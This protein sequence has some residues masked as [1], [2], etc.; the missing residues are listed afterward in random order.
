MVDKELIKPSA[1]ANPDTFTYNWDATYLTASHA[2]DKRSSFFLATGFFEQPKVEAMCRDLIK[3][4][5]GENIVDTE[6]GKTYYG[7]RL[8][9][10]NEAMVTKLQARQAVADEINK[11]WQV[12]NLDSTDWQNFATLSKEAEELL[13][14][15]YLNFMFDTNSRTVAQKQLGLTELVNSYN[16]VNMADYPESVDS[17]VKSSAENSFDGTGAAEKTEAQKLAA[18]LLYRLLHADVDATDASGKLIRYQDASA[19]LGK[20]AVDT[21]NVRA[22]ASNAANAAY[23][24][25]M[26]A[27]QRQSVTTGTFVQ[28]NASG[29]TMYIY[30]NQLNPYF[31]IDLQEQLR[32][33]RATDGTVIT[34]DLVTV[35]QAQQLAAAAGK[36]IAQYNCS[37]PEKMSIQGRATAGAK[38]IATSWNPAGDTMQTADLNSTGSTMYTETKA[39]A[40][41]TYAM[42]SSAIVVLKPQ[43]SSTGAAQQYVAYSITAN[44]DAVAKKTSRTPNN[45]NGTDVEYS[46]DKNFELSGTAAASEAAK[47]KI[48]VMVYYQNSELHTSG[49]AVIDEGFATSTTDSTTNTGWSEKIAVKDR[50]DSTIYQYF[51][52]SVRS[53]RQQ[54]GS[55]GNDWLQYEMLYREFFN[56]GMRQW[57]FVSANEP[58]TP[59]AD[60]PDFGTSDLGSFIY[61]INPANVSDKNSLDYQVVSEY[62]TALAGNMNNAARAAT[63][64]KDKMVTLL[65]SSADYR[66]AVRSAL[67]DS[68]NTY[69]R[70]YGSTANWSQQLRYPNGTLV[71]VHVLDRW[72]NHVNRVFLIEKLD[73]TAPEVTAEEIGTVTINEP[74]GSGVKA[75]DAFVYAGTQGSSLYVDYHFD[76]YRAKNTTTTYYDENHFTIGGLTPNKLYTIGAMNNAEL[77]GSAN[78]KADAEGKITITVETGEYS[79]MTYNVANA[80]QV[81]TNCSDGEDVGVIDFVLN[82]VD[83]VILNY[84]MLT[85]VV[86]AG[87]EG[88]V[89][90]STTANTPLNVTT[91]DNVTAVKLEK[92]NGETEIWTDGTSGVKVTDNGDGTKTWTKK[93][94]FSEGK[95]HYTATAKTGD[96][97]EVGNVAFTVNAVSET[98]TVDFVTTGLGTFTVY[99]NGGTKKTI[100]TRGKVTAAVGD[101]LT[102][103]AKPKT[104]NGYT[105]DFLYWTNKNTQ[106]MISTESTYKLEAVT[107]MYLEGQFSPNSMAENDQN[108]F[109]VYVNQAGNI[110]QNIEVPAGGSYTAPA[111]PILQDHV[112]KGWSKTPAEVLAS[113]E[114]TVI[115]TPVYTIGETY[116]VAIE[117]GDYVATGAGVYTCEND[118]RA[119]VNINTSAKNGS[120]QVFQYWLD[121]ETNDV[122]SYSRGYAFYA[123]K[124]TVL[125]PVYGDTAVTAEPVIRRDEVGR[126]RHRRNGVR[127]RCD[128]YG[129][130]HVD[131]QSVGRLLHGRGQH[132]RRRNGL[133]QRLPDLPRRGG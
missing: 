84:A 131:Q 27:A 125:K 1:V 22:F 128:R 85:S 44:D 69:V 38:A 71:Y 99:Y 46:C 7:L 70:D 115:V 89:M 32:N 133:R 65:K 86:S 90:A 129:Q 6:A 127:A 108:K 82:G 57:E 36:T 97:F 25:N 52:S 48:T 130:G 100:S 62:Y 34:G 123:I 73:S 17:A 59:V 104:L 14:Y 72:G 16:L 3:L 93:F 31:V 116:T 103:V 47:T 61:V 11:N 102:L 117:N 45:S 43:F 4:Y 101:V 106:R 113:E 67:L 95:H 2:N 26:S 8:K 122:V 92:A 55:T 30:T 37:K 51:A 40:D 15:E 91:K 94:A 114:R 12:Y 87:P 121:C 29:Y 120:G 33:V 56:T 77:V 126:D 10:P 88:N 112:F 39:Q 75:V 9:A 98:V 80:P 78:V 42:D 66:S 41:G 5:N 107:A 109:V 20:V 111:G 124:N 119:L 110:V 13:N 19:P 35:E 49:G 79:P 81:I 60:D 28:P 83:N 54:T 21:V 18:S 74:D 53:R 64:A 50:N 23:F 68:S 132:Q 118:E 24:P 105:Y 58:Q 76:G 63:A 96:E